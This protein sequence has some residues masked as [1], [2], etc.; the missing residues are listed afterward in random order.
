MVNPAAFGPARNAV[1]NPLQP[2]QIWGNS[3]EYEGP[4]GITIDVGL[5]RSFRIT[6]RQSLL[7]VHP[8]DSPWCSSRK[9]SVAL[10]LPNLRKGDSD[11]GGAE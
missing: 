11:A 8:S 1:A 7:R 9:R 2:A 6:N 3:A 5:S 4:G 10:I